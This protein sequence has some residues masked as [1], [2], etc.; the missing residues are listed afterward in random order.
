[1]NATYANQPVLF[2][3]EGFEA[4]QQ[5]QQH[6]STQHNREKA[7]LNAPLNYWNGILITTLVHR[8]SAKLEKRPPFFFP[9][10]VSV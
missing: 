3:D 10:L 4:V 6:L 5:M 9:A 2:K 7:W 1:M 8:P